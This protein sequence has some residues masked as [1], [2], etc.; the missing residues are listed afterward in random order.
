LIANDLIEA[1]TSPGVVADDMFALGS[2]GV[3]LFAIFDGHCGNQAARYAAEKLT[4]FLEEQLLLKK[5]LDT[6]NISSTLH[7]ALINLDD[8]FC[9][10]CHEDGR[11]WESGTTA[12]VAVLMENSLTIANLGDCRGIVCRVVDR[13]ITMGMDWNVLDAEH[14]ANPSDGPGEGISCAWKEVASVHKPSDEHERTRIE[15]ANGWITTE[16]EIPIGQLRR[17]DF[18]DED[19]VGILRRCFSDR[20]EDSGG[21]V[22]ECRSAPQRILNISRVCGELAVSRAIGDRDFKAGF[23]QPTKNSL[24]SYHPEKTAEWDCPLFLS[25]PDDHNHVFNGNLIDNSPDIVQIEIGDTESLGEF[26]LFASDGLW[27]RWKGTSSFSKTA[28]NLTI[29]FIRMYWMQMMLF[30]L[31]MTSCFGRIS[32]PS[33]P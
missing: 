10:I 24:A 14:T 20:Y 28:Y 15:S 3:S 32:R 4:L 17:M 8:A 26:L 22:R 9:R 25:Y 7:D 12:L 31:L 19:V 6:G 2:G 13:K 23:H 11:E 5:K 30:V 16:T 27:V 18:L 29:F 33:E 1:L 21:I